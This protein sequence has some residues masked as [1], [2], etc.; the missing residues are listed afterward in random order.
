VINDS[1]STTV[2]ASVAALTTVVQKFPQQ[3]VVL[4]I[5]GLSKAGSWEPLLMQIANRKGVVAS[6]VC[7]GKDG[8]LLGSHCRAAGVEHR[9]VPTLQDAVVTGLDA[10]RDGGVV[11]LSPGCASFDEFSDF[12]HRGREFKRYVSECALRG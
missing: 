1:K 3:R 4:M 11:L 9:V 8:H 2:A 5:G 12:E 6:V 7:F 10:T